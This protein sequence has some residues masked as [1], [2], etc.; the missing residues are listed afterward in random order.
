LGTDDE[1]QKMVRQLG[2]YITIPFVLAIP[3]IL[4]WFIGSWLDE[5]FHSQPFLM[6]LL[7]VLGFVA[8]FR[9]LYRIIKRFGNEI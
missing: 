4:G 9:E 5:K 2:V 8:G 3:P 7:L 1:K 6:Y